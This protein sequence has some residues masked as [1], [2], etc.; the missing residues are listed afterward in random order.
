MSR[1][2]DLSRAQAYRVETHDGRIGSVA[3]VLPRAGGQPGFLLVHT[4]LMS[5]R[6]TTVPFGAVEEVDPEL[7]R[8]VLRET[9]ATLKEAGSH[10]TRAHARTRA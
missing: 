4:G 9:P 10:G 7:R 2:D 6:L 1:V 5:C 8:V 3:A